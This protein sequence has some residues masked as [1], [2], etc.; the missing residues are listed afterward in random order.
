MP[1]F[2]AGYGG[3]GKG[4]MS[5]L[6]GRFCDFLSR[7]SLAVV[8]V[9]AVMMALMVGIG[10]VSRYTIARPIPM[11][12][13]FGAYMLVAIT[14]VGAG[15]VLRERGHVSVDIVIRLLPR[16]VTAWLMVATDIISILGT[17]MLTVLTAQVVINAFRVGNRVVGAIDIPLGP[18][19]LLMP[20]GLLL[21][22]IQFLYVLSTSVRSARRQPEI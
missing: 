3:K 7:A 16:R 10:A 11:V 8:A 22:L 20:I 9:V 2:S 19:Q 4:N 18:V 6:L 5:R 21:L 1:G 12:D 14:F 13:E 17:I 15:Y